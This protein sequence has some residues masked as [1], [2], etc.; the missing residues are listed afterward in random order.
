ME[1]HMNTMS[2][3]AISASQGPG[4]RIEG[5]LSMVATTMI[6]WNNRRRTRRD[7]AGLS[8]HML[9][10]I[11]LTRADAFFECRKPFWRK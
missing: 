4:S 10:D 6:R 3:E 5:M 9:R 7:L 1:V 11:G 8:D 2:T